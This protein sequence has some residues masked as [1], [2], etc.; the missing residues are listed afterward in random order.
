MPSYTYTVQIDSAEDLGL[1]GMQAAT[2]FVVAAMDIVSRQHGPVTAEVK[3]TV[4]NDDEDE[5]TVGINPERE[6]VE[7]HT[8]CFR[9][10]LEDF[11]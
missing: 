4:R 2:A 11:A 8:R 6:D 7:G 1:D 10:P 9:E 5:V 3:F